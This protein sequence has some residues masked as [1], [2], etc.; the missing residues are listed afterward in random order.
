MTGPRLSYDERL[1]RTVARFNEYVDGD[2]SEPV[3]RASLF[4]LGLRGEEL[5]VTVRDAE[6]A[7]YERR[8][9]K[10]RLQPAWHPDRRNTRAVPE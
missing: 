6:G 10:Q 8:N 7:R 2:I 4:A 9:S 1:E 3:F 5:A